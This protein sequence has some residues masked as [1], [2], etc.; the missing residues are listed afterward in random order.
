MCPLCIGTATLL[1]SSGT[2]A[3]GLAAALILR[4][5]AGKKGVLAPRADNRGRQ[6]G[7]LAGSTT[8]GVR[9]SPASFEG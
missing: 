5:R 4:W 9:I 2:S 1:V 8:D 3:G 6:A 7:R